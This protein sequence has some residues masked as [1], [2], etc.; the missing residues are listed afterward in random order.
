MIVVIF[1]SLLISSFHFLTPIHYHP[2]HL[3]FDRLCYFPIILAAFWFGLGGGIVSGIF[4][5][6]M[7]LSHIWIQWGGDFFGANLQQTLE[8]FVHLFIGVVTGVLSERFLRT[9]KQLRESYAELRQKTDE[10]LKVEEQLRRTERVQALAE[11]SAGIA[12]E[13][14]TPLA[15]IKGA[16]EILASSSLT[17]EQR[18]EFS[19]I[20]LKETKHLNRVVSEFL[21]FA[22]PK[23]QQ[24]ASCHVPQ[25][26]DSVLDLTTQQ[27]QKHEIRVVR[28]YA[29][30]LPTILF[31]QSQLKQVFANLIANAIQA[32]P[33]GGTL[34]ISCQL[35][36]QT[37]LECLIEDSGRGISEKD[38]TR[39]FDPFFT[40]RPN[41]T[42]LG[43]SIVH[44]ILNHHHG[45]INAFNRNGGGACFQVRFPIFQEEPE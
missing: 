13:I 28:H 6:F 21:D 38:L 10:I 31:D 15:S 29:P 32:M 41:G 4:M 11:L 3:V 9:A 34:T 19:Q 30:D 40:T 27:R 43:L 33:D 37:E 14:R 16:S 26:I 42:G 2:L 39:L 23:T 36:N 44:K 24:L 35:N 12:H 17:D 25:I 5:A 18:T 20:L 1:L 7:H 45:A 8:V 22:R